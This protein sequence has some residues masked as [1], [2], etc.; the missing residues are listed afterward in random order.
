MIFQSKIIDVMGIANESP[1]KW[2]PEY[3]YDFFLVELKV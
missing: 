1:I 2:K 3:F